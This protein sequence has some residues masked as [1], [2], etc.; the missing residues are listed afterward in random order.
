MSDVKILRLTTGEDV[1]A[2]VTHNLEID[3]VTLKQPFV[4][5]PH[6]QGPGKPVQLMMTLYSPYSKENSVDIKNANVISIVEPKEELLTSYQQN[7]SSILTSPGLITETKIP[8][9]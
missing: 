6:Q 9:I 7:T 8:K 5:I 3:T 4:I 2:K 1:I